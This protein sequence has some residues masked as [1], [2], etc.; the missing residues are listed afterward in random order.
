MAVVA[1]R[2]HGVGDAGPR[3]VRF[4]ADVDHVGA[5]GGQLSGFG[6]ISPSD[7]RGQ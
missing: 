3:P 1:Q 6:G 4:A 5:V 2:P 7:S